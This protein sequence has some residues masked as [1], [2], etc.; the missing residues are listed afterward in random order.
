MS[1]AWSAHAPSENARRVLGLA[2]VEGRD[3]APLQAL[4]RPRLVEVQFAKQHDSRVARAFEQ[5]VVQASRRISGKR[6]SLCDPDC[7]SPAQRNSSLP[8]PALRDGGV[9]GVRGRTAPQA[10]TPGKDKC[11]ADL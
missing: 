1:G 7:K 2:L 3:G 6:P 8:V 10:L 4:D 5:G 9:S 11:H